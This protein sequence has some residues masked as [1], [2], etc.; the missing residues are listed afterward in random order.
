MDILQKCWLDWEGSWEVKE[1]V[2][3][4]PSGRDHNS[5]PGNR[6]KHFPCKNLQTRRFQ[7]SFI[8]SFMYLM[9]IY[10]AFIGA[11][12]EALGMPRFEPAC[13][14]APHS[15]RG[16]SPWPVQS[17]QRGSEH[18]GC[19]RARFGSQHV[20]FGLNDVVLHSFLK[21]WS[22]RQHLKILKIHT[23]MWIGTSH[24]RLWSRFLTAP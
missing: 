21:L 12:D 13:L 16:G 11:T 10:S 23:H 7:N 17:L 19:L 24:M 9:I 8:H 5:V 22:R 18:A 1:L 3:H 20:L 14:E 15:Y 6:E 2:P 4:S